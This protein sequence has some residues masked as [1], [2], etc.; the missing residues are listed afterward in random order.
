MNGADF[1]KDSNIMYHFMV[2]EGVKDAMFMTDQPKESAIERC[3]THIEEWW[4]PNDD[5]RVD[6]QAA[7]AE[8]ADLRAKLHG[9][10][11]SVLS[12]NGQLN[13]ANAK[14]QGAAA[15]TRMGPCGKHLQG[16]W[17]P[18]Y[19]GELDGPGYCRSCKQQAEAV[20]ARLLK[21]VKEAG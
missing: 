2:C 21:A 11:D 10:A 15:E 14:L 17:I 4:V 9:L 19:E 6:T 5:R 3:L 13:D 16:E 7:R 8:L 1:D 18:A 12:L 20:Q